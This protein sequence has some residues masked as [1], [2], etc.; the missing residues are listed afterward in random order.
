MSY[1]PAPG[2]SPS[3][4]HDPSSPSLAAR[5]DEVYKNT[6]KTTGSH[7]AALN[8]R[9]RFVNSMRAA[10]KKGGKKSR[11]TRHRKSRRTRRHRK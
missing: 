9:S 3:L 11:R 7:Q 2:L 5:G 1:P 8:A 10:N 6:L 4:T